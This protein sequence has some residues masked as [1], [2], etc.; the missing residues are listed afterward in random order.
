MH[1]IN[2]GIHSSNHIKEIQKKKTHNSFTDKEYIKLK[3][4]R[5]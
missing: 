4:E 2:M 1:Q 3:K 5:G